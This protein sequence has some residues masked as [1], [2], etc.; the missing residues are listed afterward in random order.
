MLISGCVVRSYLLLC[1][2]SRAVVF[3]LTLDP[4]SY[5]GQVLGCPSVVHLGSPS[6]DINPA[7]VPPT[8]FVSL[9]Y[10]HIMLAGQHSRSQVL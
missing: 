9:L 10:R 5:S 7:L 6:G 3:D 1:P 8:S 4:L 2:F